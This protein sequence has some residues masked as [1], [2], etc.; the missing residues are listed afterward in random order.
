MNQLLDQLS[1]MISVGE[2]RHQQIIQKIGELSSDIS[3]MKGI[4]HQSLINIAIHEEKIKTTTAAIKKTDNKFNALIG[5]LVTGIVG[6][7]G[8]ALQLLFGR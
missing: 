1:N 3:E 5:L 4:V 7:I 6:A 8:S 2:M